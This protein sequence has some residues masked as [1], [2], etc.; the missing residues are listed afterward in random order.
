MWKWNL[1]LLLLFVL[2]AVYWEGDEYELPTE[3]EPE[4]EED[5]E[6]EEEEEE[7]HAPL[8]DYIPKVWEDV[9]DHPKWEPKE[10]QFPETHSNLLVSLIFRIQAP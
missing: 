9:L 4:G 2:L 3:D 1:Y 6:E 7:D 10:F 5:D 8:E